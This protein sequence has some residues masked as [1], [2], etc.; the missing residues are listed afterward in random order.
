MF[1]SRWAKDNSGAGIFITP[2]GRH[3]T[4]LENVIFADS[5]H[6][7]AKAFDGDLTGACI[8][9]NSIRGVGRGVLG[10]LA[11]RIPSVEWS[12]IDPGAQNGTAD[13]PPLNLAGAGL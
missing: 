6:R 7:L 5:Q 10:G 13:D 9:G 2:Q 4:Y 1:Y 8:L 11:N 3:G 12:G